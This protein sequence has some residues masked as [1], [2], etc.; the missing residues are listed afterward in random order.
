MRKRRI[1]DV[2]DRARSKAWYAANGEYARTRNKIWRTENPGKVAA[3]CRAWALANP[4]KLMLGRA[5]HRALKNGLEFRIS[6]RDVPIPEFCPVLGI[7]LI[8]GAKDN[9]PSIDRIINR[10]GYIPGNVVVVSWRAN[11]LKGDASISEMEAIV[12]FYK[13]LLDAPY[14]G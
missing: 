12:K 9:A 4:I 5:K 8:F 10:L 14:Q 13:E 11:R 6:E 7:K 3:S 1:S 2:A